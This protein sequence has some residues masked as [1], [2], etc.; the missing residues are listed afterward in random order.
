MNPFLELLLGTQA[1]NANP[2]YQS[3]LTTKPSTLRTHVWAMRLSWTTA[4]LSYES[5]SIWT[6]IKR[7]HTAHPAISRTRGPNGPRSICFR[8]S[9]HH[10]AGIHALPSTLVAT[11]PYN[12][13]RMM[14]EASHLMGK[15]VILIGISSIGIVVLLRVLHVMKQ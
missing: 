10:K 6:S 9:I 11:I 7:I 8:H 1:P 13:A 2:D 12:N 5:I 14:R 3:F 4:A 15:L